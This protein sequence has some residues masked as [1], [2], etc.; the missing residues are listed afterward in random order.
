MHH[1]PVPFVMG[2]ETA[3]HRTQDLCQRRALAALVPM[4]ATLVVA[5]TAG[6][7]SAQVCLAPPYTVAA[8]GLRG[9][10]TDPREVLEVPA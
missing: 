2:K 3:M 7:A 10:V 9:P 4:L 1:I 8:P 5:L 6:P